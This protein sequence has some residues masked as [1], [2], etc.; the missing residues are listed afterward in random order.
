MAVLKC[1]SCG[2]EIEIIQGSNICECEYCGVKQAVPSVRD[3]EI[4]NLFDRANA[5]RRKCE[6]DKAEAVYEKIV[7]RSPEESEAYWGLILCKFGI[8]YVEDPRTLKRIPTCHRTSYEA[9]TAD[10]NYEMALKYADATQRILYE[11]DAKTID[12]IQKR[13]LAISSQE[14]PYDVF[15]CYKE[16]DENGK[17]TKD[18]VIANDIYY[19]L[20]N[21]GF[22][23]FYAAITLEDKLGSEYEP[24]IFAALNSAKVM[25]AIGTKPEYF[26]AVWVKNEWSRFLK[27]MKS[28]R[29]KLLFPCYRDM[30]AYDLPDEFSHLQGQDMSKIGFVNDIIR[31]IKKVI[32]KDEPAHAP[33]LTVNP[34]AAS[35]AKDPTV[36]NLLKRMFMFLEDGDFDNALQYSDKILDITVECA[37]AY[38]GK[39]MIDLKVKKRDKL[40]NQKEPFDS[41]I[42]YKKVIR[43]GDDNLIAEMGDTIKVIKNRIAE[44]VYQNAISKLNSNSSK[45]AIQAALLFESISSYKDATQK[46]IEA[47][48]IAVE[49]QKEESYQQALTLLRRSTSNDCFKAASA[50]EELGDYKDA[51][52]KAEEAS[53]K[54]RRLLADEQEKAEKRSKL[55]SLEASKV[56]ATN[57]LN[58]LT[59]ER[60]KINNLV[61]G[62]AA[63]EE[64]RR[65]K[66]LIKTSRFILLCFVGIIFSIVLAAS[67]N[68]GFIAGIYLFYIAGL[69]ATV[70]LAKH[71]D[72]SMVIEGVKYYFTLGICGLILTFKAKR[73]YKDN[74]RSDLSKNELK[75]RLKII[76][77]DISSAKEQLS[78]IERDIAALKN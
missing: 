34:S 56:N 21:E 68:F 32:V 37:E 9:I 41:N 54:A 8:E 71:M 55:N 14:K 35:P 18:S 15:I 52:K 26:N 11:A 50:F 40:Q 13:I 1:K 48:N 65:N 49:Y 36:E 58:Q 47:R 45:D 19:Q 38:L 42:N 64:R 2:G 23:V 5:L 51:V 74:S 16:T 61:N 33:S 59:S 46:A 6:F 39:L 29:S 66:K 77:S 70:I 57:R 63:K 69:V 78:S 72:E 60:N 67:G 20:E 10:E 3:E 62:S 4:L 7:E 24:V 28:D 30:D 25:L 43:F 44:G 17:R 76:D 22:K 27:L 73:Q 31:G 12:A 53:E 75:S